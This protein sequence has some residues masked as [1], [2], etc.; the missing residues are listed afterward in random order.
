MAIRGASRAHSWLLKHFFRFNYFGDRVIIHPSVDI[1]RRAAPY[2]C[3]E[4]SVS[5]AKD[6]WLNIPYEAG[7]ADPDHPVIQIGHS[8]AV[9]RRS[10]I[11]GIHH[12]EIGPNVL[13]G[14]G[15]FIADHSHGYDSP[16]LPILQQG[17]TEG[18]TVIIEEGCWFGHNSAVIVD[19][20]KMLRIGKN[21]VIGANAVVTKSFP[22]NSVLVGLPARNVRPFMIRESAVP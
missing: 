8:S 5:L 4:N 14:P 2:I 13:L 7:Q 19:K 22:P 1:R 3:L 11:S 9:G 10:T 21:S 6:V 20:G 12:I 15:V 18:G 17:V 16:Y